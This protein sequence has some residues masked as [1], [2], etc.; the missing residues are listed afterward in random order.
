MSDVTP[1]T[2]S[3]AVSQSENQFLDGRENE[4]K[5]MEKSLEQTD[6]ENDFIPPE[7]AELQNAEFSE[8]TQPENMSP[9]MVAGVAHMA[10]GTYE[11][12]IQSMVGKAFKLPDDMKAEAV[13]KYAPIIVKYGPSAIGTFGQYKDE[14]MAGLFT[15]ALV[16]ESFSQVRQIKAENAQQEKLKNQ[17]QTAKDAVSEDAA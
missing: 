6:L 5:A 11:A 1:E 8:Q 7:Q 12:M 17:P 14:V 3:D 2:T 4:A 9:E 15:I 13:E 10:L 16:R